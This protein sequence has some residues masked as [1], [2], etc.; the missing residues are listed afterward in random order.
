MVRKWILRLDSGSHIWYG[1]V[2]NPA[3]ISM[4]QLMH[5]SLKNEEGSRVCIDRN[6]RK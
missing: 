6:V 1:Y 5:S 4:Y 2:I 3:W